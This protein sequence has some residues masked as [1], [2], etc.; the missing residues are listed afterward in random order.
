MNSYQYIQAL[1]TLNAQKSRHCIWNCRQHTTRTHV[2]LWK[3]TPI[4]GFLF[5]YFFFL[6]RKIVYS[7]GSRMSNQYYA[8]KTRQFF[9]LQLFLVLKLNITAKR[10]KPPT[11]CR[12]FTVMD[13][14][15]C[16]FFKLLIALSTKCTFK[17]Y[18]REREGLSSHIFRSFASK[19]EPLLS[20]RNSRLFPLDEFGSNA[21]CRSFIRPK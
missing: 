5:I 10:T 21:L 19:H 12:L 15:H 14:A 9:G 3:K 18:Q 11:I 16:I 4:S 6:N 2:H 20:Y 1:N 7:T 17:Y 8:P 13:L